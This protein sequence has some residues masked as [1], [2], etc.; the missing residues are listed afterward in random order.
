MSVPVIPVT[1]SDQPMTST[2]TAQYVRMT[3]PTC[4]EESL[5]RLDI[6]QEITQDIK[7]KSKVQ[8]MNLQTHK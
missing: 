6:T 3:R 8:N 7:Q 5:K 4:Q 1:P 2:P